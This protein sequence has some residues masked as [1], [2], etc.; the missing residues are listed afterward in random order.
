MID[1]RCQ[2][3]IGRHVTITTSRNKHV[4][5]MIGTII[6]ETKQ[7]F[8]IST[9]TGIKRVMKKGTQFLFR[10][11]NKEIAINGD[12]ICATPEERIKL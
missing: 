2:T 7:T 5:G 9:K 6:D 1:H 12:K 4:T 10:F 11:E 3:F 8:V